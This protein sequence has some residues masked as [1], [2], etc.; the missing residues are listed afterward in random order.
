MSYESIRGNTRRYE[1]GIVREEG[2][3][4]RR[5]VALHTKLTRSKE[6]A[7]VAGASKHGRPRAGQ[8]WGEGTWQGIV[9]SGLWVD[10]TH[11]S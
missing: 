9:F 8:A 4:Q 2:R 7:G 5:G 3:S 6:V 11:Y 1:Q 10:A